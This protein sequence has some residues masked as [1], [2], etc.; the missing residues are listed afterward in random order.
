MWGNIDVALVLWQVLYALWAAVRSF[1]DWVLRNEDAV[2]DT[3]NGIESVVYLEELALVALDRRIDA[4]WP[5]QRLHDGIVGIILSRGRVNACRSE[6][7]CNI[8]ISRYYYANE[9]F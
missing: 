1:S 5:V 6:I 4:A 8:Q 7:L 3:A 9:S 2:R